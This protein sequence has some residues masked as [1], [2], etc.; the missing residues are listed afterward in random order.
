M[1]QVGMGLKASLK[2]RK[3]RVLIPAV[4]GFLAYGAWAAYINR[5]TDHLILSGLAE[6]VRAFTFTS[7]G[8]LLIELVWYLTRGIKNL[9][10]RIPFAGFSTWAAVQCIAF[11]IH[12]SINP[13]TVLATMGPS[14]VVSCFYVNSYVIGLSRLERA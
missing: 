8:S 5:G 7:I 3:I 12:Y 14:L 11:S 9:K 2:N 10:I 4:L 13:E 1:G 6:G